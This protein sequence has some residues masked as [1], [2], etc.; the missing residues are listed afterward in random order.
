MSENLK[1][2]DKYFYDLCNVVAQNSKCFSRK[3]GAILVKDRTVI[4]TGYNGAPRGLPL[5]N[6]RFLLDAEIQQE[7]TKWGLSPQK[8]AKKQVCPRKLLGYKSGEGLE[9]C[10][11]GHG[12]RNA[13]INSARMGIETKGCTMYMTCEIPCSV[14][15]IE[16]INSGVLEIVVTG[17]GYYDRSSDYLLKNSSLQYRK[18]S[19]LEEVK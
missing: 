10:T 1:K 6:E 12:E 19:H 16:I 3:V 8:A 11:A 15:L 7:A 9:W 13:L 17:F 5:C 2:W 4:G 18:Y 14:C